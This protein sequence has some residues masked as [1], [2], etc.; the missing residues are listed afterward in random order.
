MVS[1]DD[2]NSGGEVESVAD[3]YD[4]TDDLINNLPGESEAETPEGDL[5]DESRYTLISDTGG[6]SLSQSRSVLTRRPTDHLQIPTSLLLPTA[7]LGS[8]FCKS[9]VQ[10][11]GVSLLFDRDEDSYH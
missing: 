11:D 7:A 9:R 1:S 8:T 2:R 3:E 6:S 5:D 10:D 4:N